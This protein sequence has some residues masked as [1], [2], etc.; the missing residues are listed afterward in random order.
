ML[1]NW[2]GNRSHRVLPGPAKRPKRRRPAVETL[3]RRI[4]LSF[5][6]SYDEVHRTLYIDGTDAEDSCT[7]DV[8][9]GRVFMLDG[10]EVSFQVRECELDDN[11]KP[12]CHTF[13]MPVNVD[14]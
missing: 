14:L 10:Q 12:I 6:A 9:S 2:F 3:E 7:L 11:G 5:V 13:D 8:N 4:V 1:A